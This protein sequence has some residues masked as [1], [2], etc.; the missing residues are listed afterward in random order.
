MLLPGY[1]GNFGT[2]F[3]AGE[4]EVS[5]NIL[6]FFLIVGMCVAYF[7]LLTYPL[8]T[9]GFP[10]GIEIYCSEESWIKQC[11]KMA[12]YILYWF[13]GYAGMWGLKWVI[14]DAIFRAGTIGDALMTVGERT[15]TVSGQTVWLGYMDVVEKNFSYF[16]NIPFF[17][18]VIIFVLWRMTAG[19]R[20]VF[21]RE[22]KICLSPNLKNHFIPCCLLAALPFIWYMAAQNHSTEHSIYTCKIISV[23]VFALFVFIAG[24]NKDI[25]NVGR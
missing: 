24:G 19:G 17:L 3:L 4:M 13:T 5:G 22:K 8:V 7:D 9:L 15:N 12:G 20:R 6:Y 14:T 23:S 16:F 10:L 21:E 2:A 18:A 25:S 1:A 11:K